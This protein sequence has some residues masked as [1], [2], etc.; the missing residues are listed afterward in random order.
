MPTYISLISFTS[1]GA[2]HFKKAP[3]CFEEA[4]QIFNKYGAEIKALYSVMG[5]YDVVIISDT[6]D[7]DSAAKITL[8]LMSTCYIKSET[9][10]AYT[11]DEYRRIISSIP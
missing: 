7:D 9:L 3:D 4:K 6:P 5:Q 11:E 1:S 10:R 2:N 8:T